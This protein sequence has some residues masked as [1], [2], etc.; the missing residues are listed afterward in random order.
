MSKTS[1]KK[2][3]ANLSREQIAGVLLDLYAARPEA[4]QWLDFFADPKPREVRDKAVEA[5]VKECRRSKWGRSRMRI[6]VLNNLTKQF[7]TLGVDPVDVVELRMTICNL[8][9]Q[10]DRV[11]YLSDAQT[12]SIKTYFVKTIEAADTAGV[13]H[14]T[15]ERMEALRGMLNPNTQL[16]FLLGEFGQNG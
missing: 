15:I 11:L 8:L 16:G 7:A 13:L 10:V 2:A 1:V 4:R 6:S 14:E 3:L 12:K 9:C 5:A